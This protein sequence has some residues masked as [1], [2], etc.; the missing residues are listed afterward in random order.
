MDYTKEVSEAIKPIL[1][2]YGFK[3]KGLNWYLENE[4]ILKI[5]N[6]QRS[7]WSEKVYLNIGVKI[8]SNRS[9]LSYAFPGSDICTRLDNFIDNEY[10]DFEN[11]VTTEKRCEEFIKL[12]NK[13]PYHFFTLQ[14][15]KNELK[16]LVNNIGSLAMNKFAKEHLGM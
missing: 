14:G 11:E 5:F 10:L 1:K 16:T 13:D 12:I 6:L 8:K 3:K 2:Q 9:I 15:S 4:V 7:A